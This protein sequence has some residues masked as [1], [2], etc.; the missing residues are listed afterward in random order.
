MLNRRRCSA[1]LCCAFAGPLYALF[2]HRLFVDCVR[3]IQETR[4]IVDSLPRRSFSERYLPR[5]EVQADYWDPAFERRAITNVLIPG[6]FD[7]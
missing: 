3:S 1:D 4:R 7:G 5:R 6:E 2:G